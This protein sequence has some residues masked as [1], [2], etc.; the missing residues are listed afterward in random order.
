MKIGSGAIGYGGGIYKSSSATFSNN[1]EVYLYYNSVVNGSNF[2]NNELIR[3]NCPFTIN[4][5]VTNTTGSIFDVLSGTLTLSSSG[6]FINNGDISGSGTIVYSGA[7]KGNGTFSF[8][9]TVIFNNGSTLGPGNSPG[10]LTFNNSNNTG[11]STYNCEINGV[12]PITDYDQLNSLSDFTISNTKLVVNWGSFVP[13]DGQ[14][15]D[16]LTCTNRIGQF[17]TVTIPSISGMVFFLVYNTNNVQLKAEAAGTFTWDGGAGTTNWNDADNWVP[18]QV[19]T[20]SK[21][22]ILNGANVIIPTG[23]TAAIKSLTIS[24]NATLTIEE[25]GA[26]NIPNT[27]NWAITISGGTSSIINHGTINLGV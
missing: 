26:L 24:G 22:V 20:L 15:F 4:G 8:N 5:T 10:K 9:G 14:T 3:T 21:D 16:I 12:N 19:P 13:T 6:I 18:N 11:P 7:I 17:A 1:G 27:S 25:N 2:T 23:Y